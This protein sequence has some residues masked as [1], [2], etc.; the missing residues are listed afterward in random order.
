MNAVLNL[1]FNF[2][3]KRNWREILLFCLIHAAICLM[4]STAVGAYTDSVNAAMR[5]GCL[6][7]GYLCI[8][9]VTQKKLR[10]LWLGF[11]LLAVALF[12]LGGIFLGFLPVA[13]LLSK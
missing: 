6:Y 2:S 9:A 3:E 4:V 10:W 12:Y 5:I 1:L 13:Y 7:A 8:P 11:G